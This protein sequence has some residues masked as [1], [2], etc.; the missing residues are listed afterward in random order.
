[1][2]RSLTC[3]MLLA[4]RAGRVGRCSS[5]WGPRGLSPLRGLCVTVHGTELSGTKFGYEC[6]S[7]ADIHA[8]KT[9]LERYVICHT[10]HYDLFVSCVLCPMSYV[11]CPMSYV[12]CPMSYVL[13][14]MSY[15]LS[16][17]SSSMHVVWSIGLSS[18]GAGQSSAARAR[19]AAR[20]TSFCTTS[21]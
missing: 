1:V 16:H 3:T 20:S 17:S 10:H 15:V 13:C 2:L 11:L 14:P 21:P 8:E 4:K 12:L 9:M 5:T 6:S 18:A 7:F 19:T